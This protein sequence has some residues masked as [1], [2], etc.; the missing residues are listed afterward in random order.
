ML[1]N[2]RLQT[3]LNLVNNLGSVKVSDIMEELR[4]SDMTVRRDLQE[5]EEQNL[6]KRVHGG[7]ISITNYPAKELSH[8]D[9][10]I[11]NLV[12]KKKIVNAAQQFIEEE[13]IIFIGPGTTMELFADKID[14]KNIKVVTNCW[15][16]FQKLIGKEIDTIL[17]G[18]KMRVKTEAFTG[19]ITNM[20][21]DNMKFNKI[22][23]SAN[24]VVDG[25]VMT[26]TIEEARTQKLALDSSVERYLLIDDTKIN[27][28]DFIA[29][30]D[31]QDLTAIVINKN[32]E[33]NYGELKQKIPLIES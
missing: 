19:D 21:L 24:G 1:K 30:Y 13:D 29:Y 14:I 3:I 28:R 10:K 16:V 5:L 18:G 26:S 27:R 20:V 7:A 25:K 12:E 31:I 17:L 6:L 22:F 4:V 8:S 23:I 2:K 9:K 33:K 15:P 11:I 32:N